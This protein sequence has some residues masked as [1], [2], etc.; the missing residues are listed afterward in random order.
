MAD[1]EQT[2]FQE[3]IGD[4]LVRIGAITPEQCDHVL[5]L[6]KGGDKRLFGEIALALGYVDFQS[7]MNY[8]QKK[9]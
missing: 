2:S 3:R 7:L 9:A 6:Q 4:G 1:N 5:K 8:L